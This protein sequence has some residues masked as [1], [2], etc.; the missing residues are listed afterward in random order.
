MSDEQKQGWSVSYVGPNFI[1]GTAASFT[2]SE[3]AQPPA[4][5]DAL[6]RR[7]GVPGSEVLCDSCAVVFCPHGDNLHFHHD[8]CP[9]CVEPPAVPDA[10]LSEVLERR[11]SDLSRCNG[12]LN[13]EWHETQLRSL[14]KQA[15]T[16]ARQ[17]PAVPDAGLVADEI[18]AWREDD[19]AGYDEAI[20]LLCKAESVLR[21]LSGETEEK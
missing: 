15:F 21:A 11:I 9:S 18:K 3:Q 20:E 4:V 10:G 2:K 1:G 16:E 17:P 13:I 5:P 12:I 8:G 7:E 14:C 19:Y 6:E